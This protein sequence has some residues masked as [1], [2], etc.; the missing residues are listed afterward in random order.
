M[1][2]E[3][4]GQSGPEAPTPQGSQSGANGQ[5]GQSG[6]Q[7]PNPAGSQSGAGAQPPAQPSGQDSQVIT[8]PGGVAVANW[9]GTW[10]CGS[11]KMYLDQAGDQVTGWYEHENSVI[12]GYATGNTLVGTWTANGVK[13]DFQLDQSTDGKSFTGHY[14]QGSSGN[15]IGT[16]SCT[17]I[18][19]AKPP[20]KPT[21]SGSQSTTPATSWT[22]TWQCDQCKFYLTQSGNSVTGW[23]DNDNSDIEGYAQGGTLVGTWTTNGGN[24][25]IQFNMSTDGQSFTGHIRGDQGNWMKFWYCV[26]K[27]SSMPPAKATA[28]GQPPTE[29]AVSWTGTWQCGQ[30]NLYLTQS[31][32]QVTGWRS[33]D[34]VRLEAYSTGNTLVGTWS[35][36]SSGDFQFT[37]SSDGKS[38][39]GLFRANSSGSWTVS[40]TCYRTSTAPPPSQ[41][42]SV[43]NWSGQWLCGSWGRLKLTQSGNQVTGTYSY[44]GGKFTGYATGNTLVGTWSEEPTYNPP[45]DAGDVQFN[46]AADGNSFTGYWRYGSSGSWAGTWNGQRD[47]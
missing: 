37:M 33:D 43:A 8:K 31:G 11:Y 29:Q 16:W 15:W 27:S 40:W 18:S 34:N 38:Y 36:P 9:I 24:S 44:Q 13:Y 32:N 1:V 23:K 42:P 22:G 17:R 39:T 14:R 10:Q 28:L 12:E 5:A 4:A 7:A 19:T 46:M 26:N 6:S 20:S 30:T 2:G 25:D 35:P 45:D 3:Q 21:A 41:P 47:Q